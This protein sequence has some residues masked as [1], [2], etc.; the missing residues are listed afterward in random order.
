MVPSRSLLP[1]VE[2][3]IDQFRKNDELEKLSSIANKAMDIYNRTKLKP[4]K[5]GIRNA[6][7]INCRLIHPLFADEIGKKERQTLKL[8]ENISSFK[9]K[10]TVFE[11][12]G[13]L[14]PNYEMMQTQRNKLNTALYAHDK[15]LSVKL[16]Q[17]AKQNHREQRERQKQQQQRET[18]EEITAKYRDNEFFIE[19][20]GENG[21]ADGMQESFVDDMMQ[22]S[23]NDNDQLKQFIMELDDDERKSINVKKKLY[24]FNPN[25]RRYVTEFMG[26][27]M[28]RY[29][30]EKNEC[31]QNINAARH[32][33][34]KLYEEWKMKSKREIGVNGSTEKELKVE[35]AKS[36]GL[37]KHRHIQGTNA[38]FDKQRER[39]KLSAIKMQQMNKEKQQKVRVQ[40]LKRQRFAKWWQK[41][42]DKVKSRKAK[43]R[44]RGF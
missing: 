37:R 38:F 21:G 19:T 31:N 1:Y 7:Q 34:G 8:M 23:S 5:H 9:P 15:K 18:R 36:L 26:D 32:K 10:S 14:N 22:I 28:L 20:E 13:S 2:A 25:T 29:F 6:K 4:S 30:R 24:R 12:G 35:D 16:K 39:K 43:R 27:R 44:N 33:Y 11:M 3:V 42:R 41:N 17:S 40:K